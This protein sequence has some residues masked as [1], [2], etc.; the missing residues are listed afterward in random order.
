MS[1]LGGQAADIDIYAREILRMRQSLNEI[2]ADA[3]NQPVDKIARDVDHEITRALAHEPIGLERVG[4]GSRVVD[5]LEID[6]RL[7]DE[8]PRVEHVEWPDDVRD[9]W[10]RR[11]GANPVCGLHGPLSELPQDDRESLYPRL[12]CDCQ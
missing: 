6:D 12:Q 1:G 3:T 9:A 2:L 7:R 8:E 4:F 10:E 11:S 5:R